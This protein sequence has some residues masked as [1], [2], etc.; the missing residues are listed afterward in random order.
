MSPETARNFLNTYGSWALITGASEGIGCEF[1]KQLASM[2][3]NVLLV[4][5][6]ETELTQLAQELS[7]RYAISTQILAVDL[8]QQSG[9]DAVIN[10]GNEL[11]IGLLVAAAGFGTSG[12]LIDN[13]LFTESDMLA[14]N[15]HA[16]LALSWHFARKF[17]AQK[18]GGIVLLS[19]VVAFQGVPGSANYAA[20]KAYVQSLAEGLQVELKPFNVDVLSVAPGPVAT[21]FAKRAGLNLGR[22]P[23]PELIASV[24]LTGLGK[25]TTIRPGFLSK[26]LGYSLAMLPRWGR[27]MVMTKV[28]AGMTKPSGK[29]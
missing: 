5:R 24:A 3:F 29:S 17:V 7:E 9:I 22:A 20:T 8:S 13:S 4:A 16:V 27:V 1:A 23:N 21:G 25:Q 2:K 14:L 6:R 11:S 10:R 19:S 15:C 12:N 18:R 26:L 28:M